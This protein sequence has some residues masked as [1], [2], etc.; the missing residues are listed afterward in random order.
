MAFRKVK[1][2]FK[3]VNI[4]THIV[5]KTYLA[6]DTT[7][8]ELRLGDGTTG[9][10]LLLSGNYYFPLADGSANQVLET[11]GDGTLSWINNAGGGGVTAS[12][13]TTFTNKSGAISQWTNDSGYLTSTGDITFTG[14]TIATGSSNANLELD[15]SGTGSVVIKQGTN[16]VTDTLTITDSDFNGSPQIYE[17]TNTGL[18]MYNTFHINNKPSGNKGIIVDTYNDG[19]TVTSSA[20]SGSASTTNFKFDLSVLSNQTTSERV[21][22]LSFAGGDGLENSVSVKMEFKP[23]ASGD[24]YSFRNDGLYM[25]GALANIYGF[26]SQS[27]IGFNHIRVDA[28]DIKDNKIST[29][30][31]N[32]DLEI[33]A[34]GTGAVT[35][36]TQVVKMANLPTADPGVA[37]QLFRSGTDLKVSVGPPTGYWTQ[38]S[39]IDSDLKRNYKLTFGSAPSATNNWTVSCWFRGVSADM[40]TELPGATDTT[41]LVSNMKGEDLGGFILILE[42]TPATAGARMQALVYQGEADAGAIGFVAQPTSSAHFNSTYLDNNWH[43]CFMQYR[44]NVTGS[45]ATAQNRI[46]LDGVDV[47]TTTISHTGGL[48]GTAAVDT[49]TSF[50]G[51]GSDQRESKIDIADVWVDFGT[52]TDWRS[53]ISY[54]YNSGWKTLG[55]AG[56]SGGAP[57][58]NIWLYE[59]SGSLVNGGATVGTIATEGDGS[60]VVT[61]YESGGPWA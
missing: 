46:Y 51:D 47:T 8:G 36:L 50:A 24:Y 2:S 53:N 52:S 61:V 41:Y 26:G 31:S 9:G 4:R 19:Y 42:S 60:G 22:T 45:D 43:H 37:S 21:G 49:K 3:E 6:V 15:A 59:A 48:A 39:A 33:D 18:M 38:T 58:P 34:S 11:D 23:T 29:N 10:Q 13:T 28:I 32:A 40:E 25:G 57:Q 35:I 27:Y 56:T 5:E 54:W 20:N 12:S 1:A 14:N 16:L 44:G 17:F 30:A 7:N 55:T